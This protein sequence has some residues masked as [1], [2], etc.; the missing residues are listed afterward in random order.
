MPSDPTSCEIKPDGG[1]DGA[2]CNM[3]A[4]LLA[5]LLAENDS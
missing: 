1:V 3:T 2:S 5:G 4:C